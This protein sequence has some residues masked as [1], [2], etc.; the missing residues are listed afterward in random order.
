M[1]V[2]PPS[3]AL[4]RLI[5]VLLGLCSA[6]AGAQ[7]VYKHV[8]PDGRI[9]FSDQPQAP[10]AQAQTQALGNGA[11]SAGSEPGS[12]TWP[13][14]LREAAAKY[15]VVLY[16][17]AN[18]GPCNTA[19]SLLVQRGVPFTEKTIGT[20]Q[21][22]QALQRL[23]GDG[24]VPYATVG[25]QGLRGFSDIEWTQTLDAAG[26]PA[27]SQLPRNYRAPAATPLVA[28]QSP[29]TADEPAPE[30][31][32]PAPAP[33]KAPVAPPQRNANPAGIRF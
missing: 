11:P 7:Q 30:G 27:T 14:A 28:V 5:G 12:S 29:V 33:R 21:D 1:K 23:S 8:G 31:A 20:A 18:C 19:R 4:T 26:Y 15:P 13:Y 9:T 32:S 10:T 25:G 6:A 24:A 17:S 16:T 2:P 22:A 3:L